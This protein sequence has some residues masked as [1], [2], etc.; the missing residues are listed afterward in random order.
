[1]PRGRLIVLVGVVV[2]L[3]GWIGIRQFG[4]WQYRSELRQAAEDFAGRRYTEAGDRLARMAVRWPGRGEVEYW[5]GTCKLKE[6]NREA[7]L[8]AWGRIPD[9]SP[10]VQE[11]A[12]ARA[13]LAIDLSRYG[14]AEACLKRAIRQRGAKEERRGL[15]GC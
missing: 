2:V 10:E 12:M 3:G 4:E 7:A 6:G 11:V 14:L 13:G 8:E 9:D 1:M 5:L 15:D